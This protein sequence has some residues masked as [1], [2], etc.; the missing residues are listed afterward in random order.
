MSQN[1]PLNITDYQKDNVLRERINSFLQESFGLPPSDYF[2]RLDVANLLKLKSALSDIHNSLTMQA[3][4]I[5]NFDSKEY[6]AI[7]RPLI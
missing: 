6:E 7:H 1:L 3:K 5:T 4:P 2:A